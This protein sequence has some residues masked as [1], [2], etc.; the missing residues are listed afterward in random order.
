MMR[1]GWWS[2]CQ[3]E[4]CCRRRYIVPKQGKIIGGLRSEVM[5]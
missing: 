4:T 2:R 1:F 5:G 3:G